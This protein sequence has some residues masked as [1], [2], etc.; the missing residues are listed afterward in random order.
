MRKF[1]RNKLSLAVIQSVGA[2]VIASLAVPMVYAQ[3]TPPSSD[4]IRVEVTGSSIKRIAAEQALPVTVLRAEDLAKAG[5]SS[6]EQAMNFIS[7]N[8][9]SITTTTSVGASTGGAAYADLRGLG[10]SRTLILVNGKRMVNNPYSSAAVDLNALPFGAVD[11][12][13]VLTDG[14]SAIYGTDAIAGV[15]N[16]I[17]RKDY[18]GIGVSGDAS[19]PTASG[20]GQQYNAAITGG[21]GNLASDGWNV[22]AGLSWRK[23]EAL[24]A[25]DRDFAKTAYI[26]DKGVNKTSGTTFPANYTQSALSG[27]YNP[28]LPNCDPPFSL[29]APGCRFDYVPFINIIPEQEQTSLIAKGSYAINKDNT[30]SLEYIQAWNSVA[31]IISPT[32]VTNLTVVPGNP[33]YP[34]AGI[35]PA[36]PNA[37]FDPTKNVTVGWRQ[38][39]VGGRASTFD[40][41]TNR[42][43]LNW[44]GQYKGWDYSATA[45][46]SKSTVKNEFTGGY[47]NST[48]IRDGLQGLS[49]A[50]WLNPFGAQSA[51][52][53]AYLES[54]KIL[55]QVQEATGTLGS[56]S[57]QASGEIWKLPAGPMMLAVGVEYI[58]DEADYK[59][60]FELIRQAASS[61]LELAEDSTGSRNDTAL[62]AELNIPITKQLEVNLAVRYDDYSDVG[63]TWNPKASFRWQPTQAVLFRGSYNEGF[64]APTLQDMYSPSFDHVHRQPV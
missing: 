12:V 31:S 17:T 50:P 34:G 35:T 42:I 10:A 39:A 19:W 29:A 60:N 44:E 28:S 25:V 3:Q 24:K 43:L 9:S 15:V 48:M 23:Q 21:V 38:T 13:E 40:S 49:G 8:Q 45:F 37:A 5:V 61:G 22:F 14:A 62:M 2:A 53:S 56:I 64:R 57:A 41:D 33:F 1:A 54:S 26:P 32:P 46:Q 7:A 4:T 52:G 18:T 55:G 6:A 16:F 63:S 59:N 51:A 11:R 58:K 27:T 47:V 36:N 20:D 30:I